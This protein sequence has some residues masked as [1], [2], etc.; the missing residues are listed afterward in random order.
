MH[1]IGVQRQVIAETFEGTSPDGGHV[2][3]TRSL[4][5][6]AGLAAATLVAGL[7]ITAATATPAAAASWCNTTIGLF[8]NGGDHNLAQI[9]AYNSSLNC[10]TARGAT[11]SA[12]GAIQRSLRYCH[13]RTSVAV[14]NNFGAITERE[15][16]VVQRQLGLD[17]DGVY[18]PNTRDRLR[19]RGSE[20]VCGTL[21]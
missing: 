2:N 5:M 11:S 21:P 16:K 13:G 7:G 3:R 10:I 4:R 19:W 9:P 20:G 1:T 14:D 6:T 17:D 18:G 8:T 15:L 12:V